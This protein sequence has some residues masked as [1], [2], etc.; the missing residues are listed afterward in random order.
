MS[1]PE[2]AAVAARGD[3]RRSRPRAH[4]RQP[5][6]RTAARR[7]QRRRAGQGV[8]ARVRGQ[9]HAA[10]GDVRPQLGA[11]PDR[12]QHRAA[13]RPAA[14][15]P[16]RDPERDRGLRAR[17]SRRRGRDRGRL[18]VPLRGDVDP[19]R[20]PRAL[21]PVPHRR[22]ARLAAVGGLRGARAVDR[23]VRGA[24]RDHRPPAQGQPVHDRGRDRARRRRARHGHVG[25]PHDPVADP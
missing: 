13:A 3:R 6:A 18:P 17:R 14:V 19:P 7:G 10:A 25:I 21:Q 11:H 23:R 22:Q 1:T 2:P 8:V 12:A 15:P 16:R 5:P 9:R 4:P 20:R 24:A